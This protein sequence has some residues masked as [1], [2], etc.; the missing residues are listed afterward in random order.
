MMRDLDLVTVCEEARCPNRHECWSAG[1]ATFMILGDTCTRRCGFCAIATGKPK[2]VEAD[3]PRRLAEAAAAMKLGHV[4]I[5]SVARDDLPDQG[6]GQFARC[7]A[8]VKGRLPG[9]S[10][11]VLTPDFRNDEACLRTVLDA[12]PEVFNHNLETVRRLSPAVR[13][14]ARY[15]RSLAVLKAAGQLSADVMTKSGMMLGLGETDDEIE[16]ALIDLRAAGVRLLTLGQY[17]R[18]TPEHLPVVRYVHPDEFAK[19]GNRAIELG[20]A[21]AASTPFARSSH[22]AAEALAAAR[23]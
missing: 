13:P 1:T 6:A 23:T 10:V 19:W 8:A 15:D 22:H 11:E 3:E 18:P 21:H 7:I 17:L 12:K 4:V 14:S 5:T 2:T 9:S 16:T 20:F